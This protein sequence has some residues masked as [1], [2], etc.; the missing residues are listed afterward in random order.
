MPGYLISFKKEEKL[1]FSLK[2]KSSI[3][4]WI[5]KIISKEGKKCGELLYF[6]C[7][8]KYLL[9]LNKKFLNHATYTDIITFDYSKGSQISGEIYISIDRVKENATKYKQPL[10]KELHRV[11]IHGVLHLCGYKDKTN[12]QKDEMRA[13]EIYALS[14]L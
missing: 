7:T 4:K 5:R 12:G 8:D 9:E 6:F 3:S 13:K 1:S 10:N 2:D 14:L 11:L